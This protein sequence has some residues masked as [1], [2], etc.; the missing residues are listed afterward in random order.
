MGTCTFGKFL[1][2]GV[3]KC[4]LSPVGSKVMPE[5]RVL[6]DVCVSRTKISCVDLSMET[7]SAAD[8]LMLSSL[9]T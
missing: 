9:L 7:L 3:V 2:D 8:S 4:S 6:P 1:L 5:G